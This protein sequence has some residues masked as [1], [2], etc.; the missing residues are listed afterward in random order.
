MTK[1]KRWMEGDVQVT[2]LDDEKNGKMYIAD[3]VTMKGERC[4]G[5]AHRADLAVV[6]CEDDKRSKRQR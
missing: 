4:C 5:V 1:V 2:L 3:V 6:R